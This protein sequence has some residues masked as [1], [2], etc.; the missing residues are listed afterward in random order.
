[1]SDLLKL[2]G[3]IVVVSGAGGGGIGTTVTRMVAEAGATVVAVSRSK[4]NL[5]E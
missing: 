5:D 1:M 2:D 3:R 4:E